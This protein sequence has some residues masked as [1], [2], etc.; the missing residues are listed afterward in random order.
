MTSLMSSDVSPING[1]YPKLKIIFC[2]YDE[3]SWCQKYKS[4]INMI[5]S[6]GI[7]YQII[8]KE[9]DCQIY[10][11]DDHGFPL[12]V[13]CTTDGYPF[14]VAESHYAGYMG[15]S[16]LMDIIKN[17]YRENFNEG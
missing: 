3:C 17:A 7:R 4:T 15:L 5:A 10:G 13:L 14:N 16:D 12:T 11:T 6:L 8:D 9:K 2:V 1:L